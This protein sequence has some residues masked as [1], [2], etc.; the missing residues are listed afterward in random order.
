VTAVLEQL[1]AWAGAGDHLIGREILQRGTAAVFV[2]AFASTLNQFPALLGEHGLL[3]APDF[4]A[5][6][7]HLGRRRSP[8]LFRFSRTRYSDRL[9]RTVCV[10][11]MVLGIALVIGLPQA[12]PPWLPTVAFLAMWALYL[13]IVS[14]GQTFY[15]F[16]W[17]TLLCEAGFAVAFLGSHTAVPPGP[18]LVYLWWLLIRLEFGAGMIKMRGDRSWRDLTA[19]DVHHQTQPMPGPLSRFAHLRPRWWHRVETLGSHV[20]QLGMPWLVLLPQPIASFA[21]VPI[22]LTQ[23]ALVLTGNYAWLNWLTIVLALSVISD[24]LWH[25]VAGGPWPGWEWDGPT[26]AASGAGGAEV[27]EGAPVGAEGL[28]HLILGE[29]GPLPVWWLVV[30]TFVAAALFVLSWPALK[31]LFSRDQ[32]MNASFNRWHLGGAYGAFGSMTRTRYEVIVEGT[33]A[34][35]PGEEDWRPYEFRGKPGD[36]YRRSPQVAP[37][38]LRLDWMMWFLAL[39]GGRDLWFDR[40]LEKLLDGDTGI[41]RLLRTDPFE[42]RAPRAVRVRLFDYR[43]ATRAE[44]RETGQW[45]MREEIGTIG[46]YRRARPR[47]PHSGNSHRTT[48]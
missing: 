23:L 15:G 7:N 46:Q 17:E 21:A 10:V 3:P 13:S 41:R 20:T 27:V 28:G 11:G 38:H 29:P 39:G 33:D 22:V 25:W 4:I 30:T 32:L 40:L 45:W 16:G 48:G 24:P 35:D 6:T 44:R 19:M 9:L 12:G 42:G 18:V 37:Y 31:N 8:S 43:Y 2:I 1:G 34:V 14:I 5:R 47:H 26:P 36:V